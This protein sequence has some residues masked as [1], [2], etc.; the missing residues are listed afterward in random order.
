[1]VRQK[2]HMQVVLGYRSHFGAIRSRN[3]RCSPKSQKITKTAHFGVQ[4][5]SRSSSV[6]L[7]MINSKSVYLQPFSRYRV[8]SIAVK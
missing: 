3:V 5:R 4:G 7:V 2:F 6:V 8:E 1:M